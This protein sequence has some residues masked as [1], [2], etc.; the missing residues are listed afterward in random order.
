[1]MYS[2]K[3]LIDAFLSGKIFEETTVPR[4]IETVMS[5]VFLFPHTVYKI[6]KNDSDFINR[7]FRNLENK[8]E[9]FFFTRRDFEWNHLLA[10]SVYL[11]IIGVSLRDGKVVWEMGSERVQDEC[12]ELVVCMKRMNTDHVLFQELLSGRISKEAAYHIGKQFAEQLGKLPFPKGQDNFYQVFQKRILELRMWFGPVSENIPIEE[13]DKYCDFLESFIYKN[14]TWF[15]RELTQDMGVS[16]DFHSFNALYSGKNLILMDTFAPKESW[17]FG[18]RLMPLFRMGV[19][20]RVLTGEEVLFE[21]FVRGYAKGSGL[22]IDQKLHVLFILYCSA[23]AAQYLYMLCKTDSTKLEPAKKYHAFL[24]KFF[25]E[26]CKG[27][28]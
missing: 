28:E 26:N 6:Y 20:I 18:H 21:E 13:S 10:P 8:E 11:S 12:D 14:S 23:N 3:P 17:M 15:E 7:E 1:M 27:M 19:D 24:Q 25:R 5:N 4:R 22:S 16:G 9:R 2:Q